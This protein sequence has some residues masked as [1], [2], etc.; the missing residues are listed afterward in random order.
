MSAVVICDDSSNYDQSKYLPILASA[1]AFRNL[2]S[3]GFGDGVTMSHIVDQ[4]LFL[5][6]FRYMK[7]VTTMHAFGAFGGHI[8]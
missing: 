3:H 2:D 8:M 7:V 5:M 1:S 6:V 4:L